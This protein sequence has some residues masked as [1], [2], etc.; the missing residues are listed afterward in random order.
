MTAILDLIEFQGARRTPYIAQNEASE[1]GLACL[2]MVAS[3]HGYKTDLLALRQRY[4]TSLKGATLKDLMEVAERLG[5]S[6]RPLRGDIDD[7]IHLSLPSILHWNLNHFVVLTKITK[8]FSGVRFHIHDPARG[9]LLLTRDEFSRHFTG[10]ILDL[11]KS[12]S[13]RPKIEQSKLRISQLWSSMSGFWSTIWQVVMLSVVLQLAALATPFFLQ[14]SID[15]VFPSFDRDLLLMLALGFGGLAIINFLAGWLRSLVL[16]TLN[17]ALSYQVTVNLFRHLMRL[18]LPWFEKRHVGDIVSRFGSTLPITQLLSQGMIAAFIDGVMALL[19]LTLMFVY[20]PLLGMVAFGALLLY[21]GLRAGFLQALRFRNIDAITTAAKENTLFIE[22]IR[23]ISA[24]KS[25]GQEGNRQRIWQKAKADAVN[26]QIKLGRLSAG[27]DA[28][29]QLTLAV[30]RVL[31]VYLAIS[32][33]LDAQMSIGMLFAL[34]AYK[35]QFLDTGVRLIEQAMNFSIIKVHLSRI[36]D[37]ALSK[38]KNE[39]L[40]S[41]AATPEFG[42]GLELRNVRFRYSHAD[43]EV[44]KGVNLSIKSGEVLGMAGPSGGGKTTLIKIIKGLVE[45]TTGQVLL[46][47]RS[48]NSYEPTK[49]SEL[50]GYVAQDDSLYAGTIAENISFFDPYAALVDIHAAAKLAHVH[51]DI[52]AMPMQ[53]ESLVGDMGST[54]SGGQKQRV[55]IARAIYRKPAL[56][57]LDE[58]TANI[59]PMME[60]GL[61]QSLAELNIAILICSHQPSAIS[62]AQRLVALLGGQL[63]EHNAAKIME[64]TAP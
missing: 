47:G 25:F 10:V 1:C 48:L 22:S 30:E 29:A 13:F 39:G 14:I 26:A 52:M 50:I 17:N 40:E 55:C 33:A 59:D 36:S 16:V 8:S 24:I 27:F 60:H 49:L 4:G 42:T 43:P 3:Y 62:H 35:Q 63:V 34:Q 57:I 20:S 32:L 38:Q 58:G 5:F 64:R 19:T 45:P 15:T 54:L 51:D 37:I 9:A 23:G 7:L 31:F 44:L 41:P 53:Y 18:P 11:L 12:E 61:M 46:N 2:A 56:L 21:A 6:A 28:A